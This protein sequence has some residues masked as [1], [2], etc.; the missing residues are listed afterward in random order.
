MSALDCG[1]A[2]ELF[3]VNFGCHLREHRFQCIRRGGIDRH[4]DLAAGQKTARLGRL[5][6]NRHRAIEAT[7]V[8]AVRQQPFGILALFE[9]INRPV[10]L[11]LVIDAGEILRVP[12]G[13]VEGDM[14]GVSDDPVEI[15]KF[16]IGRAAAQHDL[17]LAIHAA[18]EIGEDRKRLGAADRAEPAD[19]PW[20]AGFRRAWHRLKR[21]TIRVE[22]ENLVFQQQNRQRKPGAR[23]E[24]VFDKRRRAGDQKLRAAAEM[25]L[26]CPHQTSLPAV[27]E[28]QAMD[29]E[30]FV[31]NRQI[32]IEQTR[33]LARQRQRLE[34]AGNDH[35][36]AVDSGK[37]ALQPGARLDNRTDPL[38]KLSV[39]GLAQHDGVHARLT[40][41][42]VA[43]SGK[44][45]NRHVCSPG[46]QGKHTPPDGRIGQI[47]GE[48]ENIYAQTGMLLC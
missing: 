11:H 10:E 28:Q 43:S 40:L 17:D 1:D 39:G 29:I 48:I 16:A 13:T 25:T 6:C 3:G 7:F 34:I 45:R 46:L 23:L 12:V 20:L 22:R 24:E 2:G 19:P 30:A 4:A 21:Q 18:G 47:M 8:K 26:E 31:D 42:Q 38:R 27:V 44:A 35:V 5:E 36:G 33:R 32:A 37:P 9:E 15:G 14:W 41:E